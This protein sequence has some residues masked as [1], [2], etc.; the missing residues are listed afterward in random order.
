MDRA[1][2]IIN[3]ECL[4]HKERGMAGLSGINQLKRGRVWD[5]RKERWTE[6]RRGVRSIGVVVERKKKGLG[7]NKIK[8]ENRWQFFTSFLKRGLGT[9]EASLNRFFQWEG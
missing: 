6:H 7:K 1:K 3:H 5:R 8:E 2:D 9:R 4:S